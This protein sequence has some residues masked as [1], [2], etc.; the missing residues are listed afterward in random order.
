MKKLVKGSK[1]AKEYMAQIR[2]K[3][4][5]SPKKVGAI[6]IVEKGENRNAKPKAI[7]E[8]NRTKKGTF[9]GLKKI[10]VTPGKHTDT[11][12]HNVNIRVL[13][14]TKKRIGNIPKPYDKDA[15]REIKLFI[16]NDY[17]IY[18]SQT[19]PI[20]KNLTKK[21]EK[22]TFKLEPA[23]KL[24]RY[25]IDTGLK[26]YHKEYGSKRDKWYDILS[27]NDRQ[28][29]AEIMAYDTLIELDA[30]NRWKI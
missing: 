18:K 8:Y 10:G 15:V 27:T 2:A 30:G 7:Y 5:S 25:L 22:G 11:K 20:L 29:L 28:Y 9:K 23:S 26:K 19:L 3:K 12:S 16:E 17:Q 13:S 21:Y 6:K 14:G 24:F 4:K 1:E